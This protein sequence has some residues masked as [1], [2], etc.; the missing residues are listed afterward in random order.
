MTS[1]VCQ[2]QVPLP[3]T[4]QD[5]VGWAKHVK[6]TADDCYSEL[7]NQA[8]VLWSSNDCPSVILETAITISNCFV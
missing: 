4:A 1:T 5:D 2:I 3:C 7:V 8:L 6:Q